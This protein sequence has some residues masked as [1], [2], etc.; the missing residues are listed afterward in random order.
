MANLGTLRDGSCGRNVVKLHE[1][2]A[3]DGHDHQNSEGKAG[4]ASSGV[5]GS[6]HVDLSKLG[7]LRPVEENVFLLEMDCTWFVTNCGWA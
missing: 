4:Q 1:H 6:K 3:V 5:R 2:A 7:P